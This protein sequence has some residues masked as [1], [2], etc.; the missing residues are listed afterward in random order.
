VSRES[1]LPADD[2][3]DG[4]RLIEVEA[5]ADAKQVLEELGIFQPDAVIL[6]CGGASGFDAFLHDHP[7]IQLQL[8]GLL[9]HALAPIAGSSRAL[10]LSGGTQAGIMAMIGKAIAAHG[11]GATLLGVAPSK[12]VSYPGAPH[13][14]G[15]RTPLDPNHDCFVL[16][17]GE[18]WGDETT[19]MFALADAA[20]ERSLSKQAAPERSGVLRR[21]HTPVVALMANGGA[22]TE[23]ELAHAVRRRW[24]IVLFEG[25]GGL[26]DALV[27][28]RGHKSAPSPEPK[29]AELVADGEFHVVS[30]NEK[31]AVVRTRLT[32]LLDPEGREELL[33]HAWSTFARFDQQ[34]I[35]YQSDFKRLQVSIAIVG[36][37]T[38]LVAVII[39]P[40]A[41]NEPNVAALALPIIL[42]VLMT[43]SSRF[44]LGSKWVSMRGAAEAIK[45]EIFLFRTSSGDYSAAAC[46][47]S[48]RDGRLASRLAA[49]TRKVMA[50][51]VNEAALPPYTGPIPPP[52]H[53]S[54]ALDDGIS[55]L[56]VN[57]YITF[58]LGDQLKYFAG[59]TQALEQQLRRL[60][61]LIY[62][63][64]GL[65][66]LLAAQGD[67]RWIA[68]TTAVAAAVTG[69]LEYQ[70]IEY[71][72]I[73]YNQARS[74][75]E[76]IRSWWQGLTSAEHSDPRNVG[77]LVTQTERVLEHEFSGW[78][79]QMQD[80][81][82]ALQ[83]ANRSDGKHAQP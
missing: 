45:R 66:T 25:T 62:A 67:A 50:T 59:K 8:G 83:A 30:L 79:Q 53:D 82:E 55:D 1:A 68:L 49:I 51:A 61:W 54:D 64:G 11:E 7:A 13:S 40:T 14:G 5:T 12:R 75:L 57:Q 36:I 43:V 10:V 77:L 60:W 34:A 70:Q 26:A 6:I 15:D 74:D 56:D 78:V 28:A 42:S 18:R 2:G 9:A 19:M 46:V 71:T 20:L 41:T 16:V 65:G 35:R 31:P 39:E 21:G 23:S 58:R 38:V 48:S 27:E 76:S 81:L 44:K 3:N 80:K 72:L 73:K 22:V 63:I 17:E 29:I 52:Y 33:I 47:E 24:P 69:Y 37:I 4:P 32:E